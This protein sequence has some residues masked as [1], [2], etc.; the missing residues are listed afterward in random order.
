MK[1]LLVYIFELALLVISS[2][3]Y[4]QR[5]D[6]IGFV[7]NYGISISDEITHLN[8][9]EL[10]KTLA[11]HGLPQLNQKVILLPV[12]SFYI[13]S[14]EAPLFERLRIGFIQVKNNNKAYS[15][16]L[17][18]GLFDVNLGYI[19]WHTH[20][21]SFSPSLGFGFMAYS[22]R[23]QEKS[24]IP[25]SYDAAL[26]DFEG[27]RYL[28]TAMN[29]YLNFSIAYDWAIDDAG[30]FFIGVN[31]GYRLGLNKK[32]WE[33]ENDQSLTGAPTTSARG[34]YAGVDFMIQ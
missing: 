19:V 33:L 12:F 29:T 24:K 27:E 2:T 3:A 15:S 10:N 7:K 9:S 22:L 18:N 5:A 32:H 31:A 8:L 17:M 16:T 21:S 20:R 30:D 23:M 6:S 13:G 26:S 34:L 11:E 4:G 25:T 14:N 1:K 28:E